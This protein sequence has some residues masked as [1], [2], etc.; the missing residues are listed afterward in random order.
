[1]EFADLDKLTPEQI[2]N[3]KNTG[4]VLIKNIVKTE[5]AAGWKEELE[6]YV[7]ENPVVG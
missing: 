1:M 3:I 2:A 6:K 7:K 4:S 5:K